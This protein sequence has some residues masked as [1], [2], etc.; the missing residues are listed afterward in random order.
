MI[1]GAKET[2]EAIEKAKKE[3]EKEESKDI[4]FYQSMLDSKRFTF[5]DVRIQKNHNRMMN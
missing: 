5:R 4:S 1:I 2:R 3:K